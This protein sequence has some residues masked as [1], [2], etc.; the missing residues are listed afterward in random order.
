LMIFGGQPLRTPSAFEAKLIFIGDSIVMRFTL[1]VAFCVSIVLSGL[2]YWVLQKTDFGRSV[3]AVHQNAKAA[4]LM[5]INVTA[6]RAITFAA[7]V[8]ILAIAAALLLPGTPAFPGMGLRYTVITLM[9]IILGGMTNFIGILLSGFLVGMSESIGT[10][11]V[12]GVVG[13]MM[14]FIIF[15]LVLLFRPQGLLGKA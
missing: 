8:A 1:V 13:M 9:V 14:P 5:G 2:L 6:V 10:V 11:Y 3:R 7:G 15:I 4:A 12:S